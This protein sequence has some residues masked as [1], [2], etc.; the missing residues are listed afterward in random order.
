[1]LIQMA[2]TKFYGKC[3][4]FKI[5]ASFSD[6]GHKERQEAMKIINLSLLIFGMLAIVSLAPNAQ[7]EEPIKIGVVMPFSGIRADSGRY[8][9]NAIELAREEIDGNSKL[10]YKPEF[11]FEDSR[12]EP[13]V[14]V[15]AVKK[16]IEIDKVKF[17]I[18]A[19]GSSEVL[20]IAPLLESARVL[21]LTPG[22]QS[23]EISRAGDYTFRLIHNTAQEAPWFARYLAGK[24]Q[25]G[26]MHF[27][28]IETAGF[29]S[30]VKHF[31][32]AFEA[33]GKKVGLEEWVDPKETDFR[34]N[35]MR[36]KA[37]HPTDIF[38]GLTPAQTAIALRQ[39]N[40]IGITAR[41]FGIGVEGPDILQAGKLAEGYR[42]PYS[43]DSAGGE[44]AVSRFHARYAARYYSEPDT[45]AANV[46]DAVSLLSRC[47]EEV[48]TE[49]EKV[50]A[51]LYK[52]K[53]YHG[54][55]GTFS[56]DKNGDA[57]KALFVKTVKDGK[58]VK[59]E[60]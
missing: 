40:E 50:K 46:Y 58:F 14:A 31:R 12:Y 20:A 16:L 33:L 32:P 19:G 53:D 56:I 6:A 38:L 10:T 35:L 9:L 15:T 7:A 11:I 5:I 49:V 13:A 52:I 51:C 47:F 17:M 43:Y 57:V 34:P 21:A 29:T 59:A 26:V 23:D 39:A 36:I 3:C 2:G 45:I 60:D 42:Y 54:A 48:G 55:S 28:C 30:Y 44:P 41:F 1:M 37:R 25:G 27:I 4:T 8:T 22:A 18:G 24:V